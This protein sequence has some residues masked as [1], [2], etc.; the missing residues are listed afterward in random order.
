MFF[1]YSPREADMLDPQYRL[2]LECAW[3]AL[4]RSGYGS[5]GIHRGDVGVFAG[6]GMGTYYA[7]GV[8]GSSQQPSSEDVQV[9]LTVNTDAFA[10]TVS[11][12]L[13]LRGPS[14]TIQTFCSTSLVAT[15]VAC[16]SLLNGECDVALAGGV[17][18][19]IPQKQ[20]YLYEEGGMQSP[21]GH[22]RPFGDQANGMVFGD[23]VGVMVLKRLDDALQDRDVIHAV[24]KGSAI[25]N[26]GA[27]KV[28]YTAPSVLGQAKAVSA[29]LDS[30]GVDPATI[31]YVE[32]HGTA[33]RLGDPIEIRAL[34]QAFRQHTDRNQY[35]AIG[36]LK[37][38]IGHL[39][40][41]AGVAGLIKASL[42]VKHGIIPPSLHFER[43]NPEIDFEDS[44]FFVNSEVLKWPPTNGTPRRA[45]V[46]S[47]GLGGTN[48]HAIVEEPPA[49]PPAGPS[50]PR[51]LVLL[52]ART[53][54]ALETMTSTLAQYLREN[55]DVS[56]ADVAYTLQTGRCTF[57]YRRMVVCRDLEGVLRS[58]ES[59]DPHSVL[60]H[61]QPDVKRQVVFMFPG[62]GD[63]YLHM[64][65]ELYEGEAIFRDVVE[66]CDRILRPYLGV[67]LAELLYPQDEQ[68]A[69]AVDGDQVDLRAMLAQD[70]GPLSP[71]ARRLT[72]T[73]I[74]HPVVFVVEYALARLL[75]AWG[76][77]PQAMV[78]YSLGEYVAACLSGVLSLRDALHLVAKR[79]QMIQS[80]PAGSMLAVS[81][82]EQELENL[83]TEEVS[84]A[85]HN[86]QATCVLSGPPKAIDRVE[87]SLAKQEIT[88]RRL[89]TTHAFHSHMMNALADR[90]TELVETVELNPPR[91]P[92][93]SN[94]TGTWITAEEVTD[95]AYW[96]RQM[97][98]T[99]RFFEALGVL[100]NQEQEVLMLEVGP[101]QALGS[102]AKQHPDCS[103]G[104]VPL[105]LPTMRHTY[106][107]RSDLAVL[108]ETMGKSWM[109]GV[110]PDWLS[111][112]EAEARNRQSLPTYPFEH[113]S[114]WMESISGQAPPAGARIGGRESRAAQGV[115][116][117]SRSE[118]TDWFYLPSW[119]QMAPSA[120]D[121]SREKKE[122]WLL[123]SD[124]CG[125]GTRVASWLA[126]H[127]HD[128]VVVRV[129]EAF[130][131]TDER[132]FAM[133]PR[134]REDY[135]ALL[136]VLR[137]Q[138]L[139]PTRIVHMWNV[140]GD[141]PPTTADGFLE[142]ALDLG[143][144]S[145]IG[146]AQ[147]IGEL[148]PA[149]CD[150]SV[151]SSQV[152]SVTGHETLCPEK[153]T[154]VGPC[155]VIPLEYPG[156][157]CRLIDV[158]LED[159]DSRQAEA[160]LTN[161]LGELMAESNDAVVALRRH[162]RWVEGFERVGLPPVDG[163]GVS[164]LRTGGVYMVTGGLGG[165]GLAMAGYLARSV[166]ARL[167]LVSRSGL[168]PRAEWQAL[169][170]QG[171][172]SDA[173]RR[174]RHVQ[175]LEAQGSDVLVI[176]ADVTDETQMRAAVEQAVAQFG[177]IHGVIHAA[178]V[179]GKGLIQFKTPE[180]AGDV[181]APKVHGTL[182]LAQALEELDLDFVA[183]FSSIIAIVGGPG[184]VD[185]CAANA[186]LDAYAQRHA[187]GRWPIVSIDWDEW[188]WNA[189][190]EGLADL[191]EEIQALLRENRERFGI[192]F[193]EGSEAL[194]R[195]L[196][197]GLPQVMVSTRPFRWDA[198]ARERVTIE[199]LIAGGP[200][201]T[202]A[203]HPRPVL[204]VPYAAPSNDLE[205][206][207]AAVWSSVL[208]VSEV[209]VNDSFFE[210]GGNSLIGLELMRRLHVAL[211]VERL[212][213]RSLYEAPTVG[214]LAK[215]VTE[216]S[217]T[218]KQVDQRY[219]RGALR[220]ESTRRLKRAAREKQP[221]ADD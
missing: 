124:E 191:G 145:L 60:S 153:A 212:P 82:P 2:F 93:L 19:R 171:D 173:S 70:D 68:T 45:G 119:K 167:V 209:G 1:G 91:I 39:D 126:D 35:C 20:G 59:N 98:H 6:A 105:I 15:H 58:L 51:Q 96:A 28:G 195:I 152:L 13:D 71:A 174:I 200:R 106:E 27:L 117:S 52:S 4:E 208:G 185:Y 110:K 136:S 92:Y 159:P 63:H 77:R 97:C 66:Q 143:F 8:F 32:A 221:A 12:K 90:V 206:K 196:R 129:G 131:Q 147:A 31:G 207:I 18:I 104:H 121:P 127:G 49:R 30:A 148:T 168:P 194:E 80:L 40:R 118:L 164:A 215:L 186:F 157:R 46:N 67:E 84:L 89:E 169:A 114:Y 43:P 3:E 9:P 62:I 188:K 183:L 75:M 162:Q 144:N 139:E 151:V 25:N 134:Q 138:A 87:A 197:R 189:W 204:G 213:A 5:A 57:P 38:N 166:D 154:V 111:F 26:D 10:T 79:S 74:A 17:T 198:V 201:E 140:T 160:L 61:Y 182:T 155:R 109:L 175:E 102:F 54:P 184:Q 214:A 108:L 202:Q 192:S 112:Y 178:G 135:A 218:E 34:A 181:L 122:C 137:Q 95:S 141:A 170:S 16:Q 100:L 115:D 11:Y 217:T 116:T 220:R 103:H 158:T 65:R 180:T 211:G 22:C 179:P 199:S 55:P 76:V 24:I 176:A 142:Q 150:L 177:T 107:R 146:L 113:Q 21:D 50:R 133:R 42:A 125:L 33:T 163:K 132:R 85:A 81:L 193:E 44:P 37:G 29:A 94:L 36:S 123:F 14:L 203:R 72:E 149:S 210:L 47:L 64:A 48:A 172:E 53:E 7:T 23:G 219:S 216:N 130:E 78:G 101:G 73:A 86:G 190:E 187:V 69:A 88:C 83:L 165:I 161:L 128:V 205:R 120:P 156:T 41:A 99:I 56:L